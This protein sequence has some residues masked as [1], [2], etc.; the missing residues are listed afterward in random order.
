MS[1]PPV[2]VGLLG[3][4]QIA[5]GVHL[6]VLGRLPG[7]RVAALAE[8]EPRA[9]VEALA[10]A[11]GAAPFADWRA[12]VDARVVDAVVVC[13]PPA[14]HAPATVAAFAA[15]LHVYLEKPLAP[16][17]AEGAD[18]LRAWRAAGTVGTVGFNFRL[19]PFA[20]AARVHVAAGDIGTP[21]AAQTVFTGAGDGLPDWKRRRETGGGVLL[22]LASHHADLA[23][24]TFQTEIATVAAVTRSVRAEADTA[25]VT[26]RLA[27]GV[28][29]QS[30][31]SLAATADHRFEV[32]GDRGRLEWDVVRAPGL[33]V[34][35]GAGYPSRVQR[36][37][38]LL[39]P[40]APGRLLA[41]AG[42]EPSFARAL[43]AFAR[44]AAGAPAERFADLG[45]GY[46]SL[47]A[48]MAAEASAGRGGVPV[49]VE[50]FVP[51]SR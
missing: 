50:A 42:H 9:R 17:L 36:A 33:R 15:G 23:R 4:G 40:L 47:A 3:C 21:V 24:F 16:T 29:V 20:E 37:T 7:V 12:L 45:D 41:P 34:S 30:F 22:D 32:L 48:V 25:D 35:R 10:L 1:A 5:R 39:R 8:P 46:A 51:N 13:L 31:V 43:G 26:F 44:A 18:V 27:S 2:R 19:N 14:L 6:R 49:E 11:P 28:V 38:E